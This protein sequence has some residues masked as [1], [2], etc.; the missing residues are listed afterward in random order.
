VIGPEQLAGRQ[1]QWE[2]QDDRAA[3]SAPCSLTLKPEQQVSGWGGE[4]TPGFLFHLWLL[5]S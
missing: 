5:R 1:Q 2:W 4:V 3:S